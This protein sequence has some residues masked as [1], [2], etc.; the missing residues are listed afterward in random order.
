MQR[1]EPYRSLTTLFPMALGLRLL[2]VG[3]WFLAI[4]LPG[5]GRFPSAAHLALG[6][7]A[8]LAIL[9]I[10]R[11]YRTRYGFV[12]P[13]RLRLGRS[14][15]LLAGLAAAG[16][17]LGLGGNLLGLGPL[18]V[19]L[20]LILLATVV[21]F[22]LPRPFAGG[23]VATALLVIVAGL[24][25]VFL[26]AWSRDPARLG[27]MG[28]LFSVSAGALLCLAGLAEHRLL[29]RAFPAGGETPS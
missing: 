29:A 4:S 13:D 10:H 28:T 16:L 7:V 26:V 17:A 18:V 3:A 19:I 12:Q 21:A 11:W 5:L 22:A 24:C 2:P 14:W 9:P 27:S 15:A 6:A 8:L 25:A 20:V 1:P 23:R